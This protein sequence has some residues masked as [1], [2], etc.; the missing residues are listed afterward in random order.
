MPLERDSQNRPISSLPPMCAFVSIV[1]HESPAR[2]RGVSSAAGERERGR[3]GLQN[4]SKTSPH[5][6]LHVSAPPGYQSGGQVPPAQPSW[7]FW[8]CLIAI[9][10]PNTT[11]M[12]HESS[13]TT[14]CASFRREYRC[15]RRYVR[16]GRKDEGGE[17]PGGPQA[18][19]CLTQRVSTHCADAT[20]ELELAV[21]ALRPE[22]LRP[23]GLVG[24]GRR[25]ERPQEQQ[26][27]AAHHRHRGAHSA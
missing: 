25:G 3:G 13:A 22:V 9:S 10:W 20:V 1:P 16:E 12:A 7:Q 6:A 26:R 21:H 27:R 8:S 2:H 18:R 24:G 11:L 17:G 23:D 19:R 15:R 4:G 14:S 5:G